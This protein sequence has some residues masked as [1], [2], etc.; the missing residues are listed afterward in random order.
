M[1]Q[2]VAVVLVLLATAAGVAVFARGAVVLVRRVGVGRPAP[3]RLRPVGRR[4]V[5]TVREVLGH[6]HF[7]QRPAVRVA[8]W[9]VMVS[10]PLL[11]LTLLA[12]YGQLTDPAWAIPLLG[13]LPPWE[14]LTEVFAWAGLVGIGWLVAVRLRS[15]PRRSAPV[16]AQR[17]SR[18]FGST[19]WQAYFVEAVIAAV[20]LCVL[21]LRALEYAYLAAQGSDL[22]SALHFPLTGWAGRLLAGTA[23]ATLADAITV[24]AAVKILVSMGWLVVVGLQPAMGVAWHRFLALVNVYARREPGGGP[25]LGPA[26]PMTVAGRPV[27]AAALEELPEDA[28]LGVGTVADFSWK[29]LLDFSTCT[30]CG[31]CQDQ[32]PAWN[33]GKPLSPKLFTLALRDHSA[34]AAPFLRAAAAAGGA[35]DGGA[36]AGGGPTGAAAGSAPGGATATGGPTGRSGPAAAGA[37]GNGPEDLSAL[38]LTGRDGFRPHTGDVLGALSAAGATGPGGVATVPGELVPGVVDPD[39]LW[40]CT[41]CGACV[42]QCP[43][44]IEHVDHILDLR[45][46]Q[47]LMASAFPAELGGMFRKLESRGNP[48]G[49]AARK[50][51][52]WAKDLPFEVPVVGA[53]VASA[54]EVDYLFWVGCAGAFEDRARRTTRAVAELLHAAGVSFAV[55]GDG[56]SCT[57]DPARRAGNEVLFQMLAAQNVETLRDAGVQ[58][59]VVTCA[60]CFN[61]LAREYPQLGGRF[62]VVHHTQLLNRLVREGRL[63]PVPPPAGEARTVTYHDPCYLGRHNQVYAPPRE[64]LGALPEVRTVEMPRSGETAMCCGGGG[65]RVWME[66]RIG[67]RVSTERAREATATGATAVATACP[68]CTT[69]LADGVAANGSDAEVLDVAQLLLAGVRRGQDGG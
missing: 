30:E 7:R 39:V 51:L 31:R 2:S 15:Q 44:D 68:F 45:R 55:L 41:T 56:E 16:D 1:L 8:H 32:C 29:G 48:W 13:H 27:D 12:G 57:G 59:I 50:R 24:V 22:A 43:V 11:F 14:W 5:T 54:G 33:T 67:T 19:R 36:P 20:V 9:A 21:A 58:R 23:P 25:A 63:T 28:R 52:D 47:V 42:H 10:F 6:G 66:E 65:A 17:G 61:T 3:G 4:L 53:D 62:D 69:M 26:A 35:P 34:A 49:M 40:S 18:F 60:H 37:V 46:H 38:A 64:L